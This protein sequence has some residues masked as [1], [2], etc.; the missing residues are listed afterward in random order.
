MLLTDVQDF[1]VSLNLTYTDRAS[2]AASV[3]VRVPFVDPVV[4]ETAF[5]IP[6]VMKIADGRGKHILK[7]VAADWLPSYVIERPKSSFTMPLRAWVR[8]ELG[9]MI[10]DYVLSQRGL[11]G[12]GMLSPEALRRIVADERAGRADNAQRIWQLLTL[13]QWFRNHGI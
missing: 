6:S 13:E 9:D 11:A 3:E 8:N 2:M 5:R 4:A 1:L 10:D 7:R 12:R